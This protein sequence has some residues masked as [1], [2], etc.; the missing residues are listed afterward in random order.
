M[1][2]AFDDAKLPITPAVVLERWI[3]DLPFRCAR[4]PASSDLDVAYGENA[5]QILEEH[6]TTWITE[7]DWAWISQQGINT[8]RIPVSFSSGYRCT[9]TS[10]KGTVA[11]DRYL[12]SVL[13]FHFDS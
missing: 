13:L 1:R 11:L 10:S 6:W 4:Q 2:F 9:F 7:P 12:S 8:V 5:Q 3:T